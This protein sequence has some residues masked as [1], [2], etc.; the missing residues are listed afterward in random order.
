MTAIA[1]LSAE[2]FHLQIEIQ[3]LENLIHYGRFSKVDIAG[4]RAKQLEL[5]KR[6]NEIKGINIL[7]TNDNET[8]H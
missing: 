6:F 7:T 1:P 2:G 8:N 3:Q 4:L 5:E